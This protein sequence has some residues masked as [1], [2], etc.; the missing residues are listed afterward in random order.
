MLKQGMRVTRLTKKV[1][2][3]HQAGTVKTIHDRSVEVAWD[4]GRSS[5]VEPESLVQSAGSKPPKK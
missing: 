5:I 4:D 1:G 3:P 2:Q